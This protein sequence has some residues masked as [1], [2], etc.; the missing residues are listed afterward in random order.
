MRVSSGTSSDSSGMA[1]A[2]LRR[3][4]LSRL[5]CRVGVAQGGEALL[6]LRGV[7]VVAVD[8]GDGAVILGGHCGVVILIGVEAASPVEGGGDLLTSGVAG[9]SVRRSVAAVT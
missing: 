6:G 7:V 9:E 8:A 5:G 3:A 2:G 4:G 1:R